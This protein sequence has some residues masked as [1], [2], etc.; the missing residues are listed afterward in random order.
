MLPMPI[1]EQKL[2]GELTVKFNL[3]NIIKWN[4]TQT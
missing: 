2:P 1:Y 4:M 3:K